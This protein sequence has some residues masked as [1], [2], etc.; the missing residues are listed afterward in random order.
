MGLVKTKARIRVEVCALVWA[1]W[2]CRNEVVFNRSAKL[3][4][5]AGYPQSGI[6]DSHVVQSPTIG[7]AGTYR[8]WM[9]SSNRGCS[10]YLL[11][12][13]LVAC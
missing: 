1:I 10:G 9:Q 4:K 5:F 13:W 11:P 7:A 8:Y 12:G 3:K 6:F 2:N